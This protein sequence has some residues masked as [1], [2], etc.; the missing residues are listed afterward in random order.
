MSEIKF[1]FKSIMVFIAVGIMLFPIVRSD[2]REL[3]GKTPTENKVH[4][5]EG[6]FQDNDMNKKFRELSGSILEANNILLIDYNNLEVILKDNKKHQLESGF[7]NYYKFVISP[8]KV[9]FDKKD[10]DKQGKDYMLNQAVSCVDNVVE[11]VKYLKF[12]ENK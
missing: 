6:E 8:N 9:V 2:W 4:Q 12:L 1:F 5:L 11:I 3:L 7:C 10:I